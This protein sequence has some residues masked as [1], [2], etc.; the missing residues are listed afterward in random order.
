MAITHIDWGIVVLYFI[1]MIGLGF[2][3]SRKQITAS[4][5][6]LGNRSMNPIAIGIS[7]IA[8]LVSTI[9]YLSTP[10]ELLSYGPWNLLG[11]LVV[12]LA[13]LLLG[14]LFIPFF[15]KL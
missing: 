1:G 8:T 10:G 2:W 9:S 4:E 14:V 12:P 15:M 5:F 6:F 7:I 11:M 13:Y 3:F